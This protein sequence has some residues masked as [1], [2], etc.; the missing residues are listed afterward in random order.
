MQIQTHRSGGLRCGES[1][2]C[3]FLSKLSSDVPSERD[4]MNASSRDNGGYDYKQE[5]GEGIEASYFLRSKTTGDSNSECNSGLNFE[6]LSP[7]ENKKRQV[8]SRRFRTNSNYS[9]TSGNSSGLSFLCRGGDR[10]I[11]WP[12]LAWWAATLPGSAARG[13]VTIWVRI[14]AFGVRVVMC[15]AA[16]VV[17]VDVASFR[18]AAPP[19]FREE[20]KEGFIRVGYGKSNCTGTGGDRQDA[21][22]DDR[23]LT[24]LQEN[25][26]SSGNGSSSGGKGGLNNHSKSSIGG[27]RGG[28]GD[29]EY[30]YK[31]CAKEEVIHSAPFCG[32]NRSNKEA[33]F[34]QHYHHHQHQHHQVDSG[35]EDVVVVLLPTHRSYLDFVL[36]SLLC[37]AMRSLPGLSWLRVPKVAAADGPFGQENSPLR[38]IMEKLG[39]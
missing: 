13:G 1:D 23:N 22:E 16:S 26:S 3:S 29:G 30:S 24:S 10:L 36:V 38:L 15:R 7:I 2:S 33:V 21:E 12:A 32:S 5:K 17:A 35:R 28:G 14:V 37:A 19:G 11:P 8:N 4:V 31:N 39:E 25:S 34:Q 9:S 27:G 6:K 20:N 18:A